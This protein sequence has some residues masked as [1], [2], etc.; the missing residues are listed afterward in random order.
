MKVVP[1]VG[2]S[3]PSIPNNTPEYESRPVPYGMPPLN[4]LMVFLASMGGGKTT[5]ILQLIEMYA[6]THSWD[7]VIYFSPTLCHE[8]KGKTF[9][10]KKKNFELTY[11]EHYTDA[12]LENEMER[13]KYDIEEYRLY[14]HRLKVWERFL[15]C[16]NVDELSLEDLIELNEMNWEKPKTDFKHG[17][18]SFLVVA[19]DCLASKVFSANCKGTSTR[20][21]VTHRHLSCCC[22]LS[23]QIHAN[24][25]PRQIRGVISLWALW[26]CK[27]KKLQE[28][29]A[30]E[31]AMRVPA[32]T[33]IDVWDFA[34]ADKYDFLFVNAKEFDVEKMF[35]RGYTKAITGVAEVMDKT[36]KKISANDNK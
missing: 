5:S 29:I 20:F 27:S 7:R 31:L 25:V 14:Q 12:L 21:F 33:F 10:N 30:E 23:V 8:P 19:D 1:V 34:C 17:F 24:G 28:T 22:I 18:P 15:R 3:I 2:V 16:N 11:H 26:K 32:D 13:M 36:D 6:K 9:I 4:W 35:R